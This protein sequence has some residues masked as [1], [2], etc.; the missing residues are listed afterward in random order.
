MAAAHRRP[1]AD[2]NTAGP[3]DLKNDLLTQGRE[4][5]FFQAVRLLQHFRPRQGEP[6]SQPGDE[7]PAVRVRPN[8]SLAFPSADIDGI[9]AEEN[10]GDTSYR[11][12]ANFLG[13]YGTCSPL[14][15]FYTEDLLLEAGQDESV[16]RDFIDIFNERL[17]QLLYRTW[18][19]SRWFLQIAE[20]NNPVYLER[21]Y[22]L[23]GLGHAALR[24]DMPQARRLLRYIGLLSQFPRSAAGLTALLR[25]A[26][27][28]VPITIIPCIPR[29]AVIP[30]AQRMEMGGANNCLGLDSIVGEEIEDRMGKFRIQIGPLS[31][32]DFLR[33]T[34][35]NAGYDLLIQ[36][37][38]FYISEP[39]AYDVEL[40]LA[41]DQAQTVC[42]GD[43]ARSMLGVSA[44]VFSVE[45]LGEVRSCFEVNRN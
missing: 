24:K 16:S 22:C 30:V 40:I 9:A 29:S 1:S 32:S 7:G 26:L 35:G 17:Y 43:A 41:A 21:L 20:E 31:Q 5:S 44:W 38:D 2:L 42:L 8:L 4:F 34:P 10:D 18:T 25:D 23:L 37:T 28:D 6:P 27:N 15:T 45:S 39:L 11:I 3:A 14:P 33:F 13:L 36:L 19:R 12:V